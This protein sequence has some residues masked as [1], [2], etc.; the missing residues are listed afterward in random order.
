MK[1]I[2]NIHTCISS[3]GFGLAVPALLVALRCDGRSTEYGV[4]I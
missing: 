4:P 3:R 2:R 1:L